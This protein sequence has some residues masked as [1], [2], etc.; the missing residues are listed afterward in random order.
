[1]AL[2]LAVEA[3]VEAVVASIRA[4]SMVVAVVVVERLMVLVALSVHRLVLVLAEH[5]PV[6]PQ[7]L[8][9]AVL[10]AQQ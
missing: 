3:Q 6:L 10:V 1:M 4:T 9:L 5:R 8:Q 2:L 7:H